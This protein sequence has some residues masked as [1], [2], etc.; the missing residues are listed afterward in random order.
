MKIY[1][2]DVLSNKEGVHKEILNTSNSE[3]FK[4][5]TREDEQGNPYWDV[6]LLVNG[7]EMEISYFNSMFKEMESCIEHRAEKMVQEKM[8]DKLWQVES[9]FRKISDVFEDVKSKLI[10]DFNIEEDEY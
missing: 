6:S 7:V 3:I 1:Y 9:E 8:Q 4:T 10:E 5:E 2:K